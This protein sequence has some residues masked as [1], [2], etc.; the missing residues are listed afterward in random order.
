M[1]PAITT[2]EQRT[3]HKYKNIY[4]QYVNNTIL[5]YSA[6]HEAHFMKQVLQ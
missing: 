6:T 4:Y 1:T 2:T 3:D 5:K